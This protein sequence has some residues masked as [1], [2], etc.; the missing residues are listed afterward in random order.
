MKSLE[1]YELQQL[2]I[3][4]TDTMG[5][6]QLS[7]R[8][9][10]DMERPVLQ[11]A[12][13]CQR[14][15]NCCFLS[16]MM[17]VLPVDGKS[18]KPCC[19]KNIYIKKLPVKYYAYKKAWMN[20]TIFTECLGALDASKCVHFIVSSQLCCVHPQATSFLRNI[21]L[22]YYLSQCRSVSQPTDF[23]I[24]QCFKHAVSTALVSTGTGAAADLP[25]NTQSNFI[26]MFN[27]QS[28]KYFIRILSL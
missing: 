14:E 24:T 5:L 26:I 8:K 15:E 13:K 19:F 3:Y 20:M 10:A 18:L 16:T 12:E 2:Y 7:P 9:N 1:G 4:I 27:T 17:E 11:L 28:V 23:S 22:E 21:R 25:A 6:F